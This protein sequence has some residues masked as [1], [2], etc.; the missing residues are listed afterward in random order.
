MRSDA[1]YALE[2]AVPGVRQ[3]RRLPDDW[4]GSFEIVPDTHQLAGEIEDEL[5][6]VDDTD[7]KGPVPASE[8]LPTAPYLP[9]IEDQIER[10]ELPQN[11]DYGILKNL[12][13]QLGGALGTDFPGSLGTG[14]IPA[15]CRPPTDIL[16]FYLPWHEF[17]LGVW[18][19]YL[20]VQGITALGT[21][22]YLL[23]Q[24]WLTRGEANR[25]AKIF[26]FHHE[27]FHDVAETFAARLE[28]SHRRPCYRAGFR[29]IWRSGFSGGLLHEEALADAYAYRKVRSEAFA[30]TLPPGRLRAFKRG[31][32]TAALRRLLQFSL[33]PYNHAYELV[34]GI[35]DW[36]G[37]EHD[38]QESNHHAC[39]FG[40]PRA[41]SELW[42]AFGYAMHP[43]LGRNRSFSYLVD[44]AHP[45]IRRAL[46]VPHYSRREFTRR[47]SIALGGHEQGGGRHPKWVA[48]SGKSVPVPGHSDLERGTCRAILRQ[49]GLNV[50]LSRFMAARDA[51]L[52]AFARAG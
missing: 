2:E 43:S 32:A 13:D 23:A 27:A 24:P 52:T 12:A 40:L 42:L 14:A 22:L 48:S 18:G 46:H 15:G 25:V 30:D 5:F 36:D 6:S 9:A 4:P 17:H 10:A 19:I 41:A 29:H 1:I 33:P 51:E 20:I 50:P 7:L 28:V 3:E 8:A 44:R 37:S 49:F 35:F 45:A 39:G 26:L 21:D 16:A 47:L 38:F 34:S 11:N 31:V